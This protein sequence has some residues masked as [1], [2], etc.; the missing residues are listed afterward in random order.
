MPDQSRFDRLLSPISIQKARLKN[1][2]V[3]T[4]SS[5]GV[6]TADGEVSDL[7]LCFYEKL[8]RGGV[9][10]IVVEHGFVDYPRGVT[11]AGRIANSDDRYLPGLTKLAAAM[12]EGG[13]V[14]IA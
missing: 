11:G 14:C 10:M 13:A 1:R 6:A 12:H 7:T 2:M 8:A 9:G 4:A 3:K 5:L